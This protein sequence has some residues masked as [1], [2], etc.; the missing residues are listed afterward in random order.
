MQYTIE[1]A[2]GHKDIVNIIG[3]MSERERKIK[4]YESCGMC[5][6]CYAESREQERLK[7]EKE[8]EERRNS[9]ELDI[10][11]QLEY[12][13]YCEWKN[14]DPILSICIKGDDTKSVKDNL[15]SMGYKWDG[16]K[17]SKKIS[18][19]VILEECSKLAE[20]GSVYTK[21]PEI[22]KDNLEKFKE[23]HLE[24]AMN[25]HEKWEKMRI[26]LEKMKPQ[27]PEIII[28][29]WNHK[30]YGKAGNFSI[31]VNDV[32]INIADNVASEIK[33]YK[34]ESCEWD[35]MWAVNMRNIQ[36]GL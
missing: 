4:Y 27:K 20:M 32:K 24:Y 26:R 11:P 30:I 2:C 22:T 9:G 18:Q 33:K 3:K 28:G 6:K 25:R 21:D 5:Q 1:M 17:W 13:P 12:L 31:Y 29:K 8:A 36:N 14:E 7:K 10:Q 23:E 19:A 34:K 35:E 16:N 15:K